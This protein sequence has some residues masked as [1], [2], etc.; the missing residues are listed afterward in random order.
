MKK[1]LS[2]ILYLV[3]LFLPT[4]MLA[5]HSLEFEK[6]IKT[7]EEDPVFYKNNEILIIPL[8]F[9][10]VF[11]DGYSYVEDS[12]INQQI[13]ILN[14][15]FRALNSDINETSST[16]SS[17]IGDAKIQ[18]CLAM[19]NEAGD[20]VGGITHTSTTEAS[21]LNAS[22]V[23]SDNTGG[24]SPWD[25]TQYLNVW[26]TT[27]DSSSIGVASFP[28]EIEGNQGII[29]NRKYFGNEVGNAL[30]YDEGKA[31][32]RLV[33]HFL[34]LYDVD[35][36]GDCIGA[37]VSNCSIE[38][39][40]LC[41]TP[42]TYNLKGNCSDLI[43]C[44]NIEVFSC[45][46]MSLL[47]DACRFMFTKQ[48]TQRM[49]A[50]LISYK[51]RL[52]NNNTV[53]NELPDFDYSLSA[54]KNVDYPICNLSASINVVFEN[55]GFLKNDSALI[56]L[57]IDD[58]IMDSSLIV[59]NLLS[60][61]KD[62]ISFLLSDL[63]SG[64]YDL[65]AVV[66]NHRDLDKSNDT[67]STQLFISLNDSF[68]TIPLNINFENDQFL[69]EDYFLSNPDN[70]LSWKHSS[71][72]INYDGE[73][74]RVLMIDAFNNRSEGSKDYVYIPNVLLNVD[75]PTICFDYA[76][77]K[78]SSLNYE[79]LELSSSLDCW[80]SEFSLFNGSG[81]S[82]QTIKESQNSYWTPTDS[83]DWKNVCISLQHLKNQKTSFR[84]SIENGYGN[85]FYLGD[86]AIIDTFIKS[87]SISEKEQTN[88]IKIFPNPF[89]DY[90]HLQFDSEISSDVFIQLIDIYGRVLNTYSFE[91]GSSKSFNMN[92]FNLTEGIYILSV[93]GGEYSYSKFLYKN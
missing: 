5:Q 2:H 69:R 74:G 3:V 91:N 61:S 53:C 56:S 75:S 67:L 11:F 25:Q 68:N 77:A 40:L 80:G 4:V 83:S 90:I 45:N 93:F 92:T 26:I 47:D 20:S 18:F 28:W 10:N 73:I 22:H 70:D 27:L 37:T 8:V 60:N 52:M 86:I 9:H 64:I 12:I 59:S 88:N 7:I 30:P 16:Y 23:K 72:I 58:S 42:P 84:F 38:G 66:S 62:S 21:F 13:E 50:T 1:S 31:I 33:G 41:D 34:G 76:Y 87:T 48:Q 79:T 63:K 55:S 51:S 89:S 44:D 57:F 49:R 46:F 35:Y 29:I 39:D 15:A 78:H 65:K 17:I 85:N 71:P 81:S 54:I 43:A 6:S 14:N 32:I 24:K 36:G 19:Y 82:L